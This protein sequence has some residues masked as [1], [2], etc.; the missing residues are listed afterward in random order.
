MIRRMPGGKRN[1]LESNRSYGFDPELRDNEGNPR[2]G[3]AGGCRQQG[4]WT[5]S[6]RNND[7]IESRRL[8]AEGLVKPSETTYGVFG[9]LLL[10]Q[11]H[12]LEFTL[13]YKEKVS[14]QAWGIKTDEEL[15]K[16]LNFFRERLKACT[17]L[18]KTVRLDKE[19][20]RNSQNV[21]A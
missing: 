20:T 13:K 6:R 2:A 12:R 18:A 5:G 15:D 19:K 4:P 21:K 7:T 9:R 1:R 17:E 11:V 8:R 14:V 16:K 3:R 10:E